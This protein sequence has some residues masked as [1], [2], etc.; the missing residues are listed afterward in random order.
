MAN[1]REH[2][3]EDVENSLQTRVS[4][5]AEELS[6]EEKM[7]V[8][9]REVVDFQGLDEEEILKGVDLSSDQ[10][11]LELAKEVQSRVEETIQKKQSQTTPEDM[12]KKINDACLALSSTRTQRRLPPFLK[13]Y[14]PLKGKTLVM[15]DDIPMILTSFAAGLTVATDGKASFIRHADQN[16]DELVQEIMKYNPDI[17][18]MDNSLSKNLIGPNVIRE[19][20][21]QG[22]NGDAVGFSSAPEAAKDFANAGAKGFVDKVSSTDP[23]IELA[24]LFSDK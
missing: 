18:L 5:P 16:M 19:L 22:F 14:E 21:K 15:V 9:I 23:I 24:K 12:L 17:V 2:R 3:D 4:M 20:K 8:A 13:E 11:I 6:P 10:S 7:R 1:R